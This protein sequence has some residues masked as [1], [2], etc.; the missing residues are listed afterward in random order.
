MATDQPVA[1]REVCEAEA[2]RIAA[3]PEPLRR[4]HLAALFSRSLYSDVCSEAELFLRA[5]GDPRGGE[6][7][8]AWLAESL[9]IGALAGV[10]AVHTVLGSGWAAQMPG[11]SALER[12][13]RVTSAAL[14]KFAQAAAARP[15]WLTGD[16]SALLG[17]EYGPTSVPGLEKARVEPLPAVRWLLD[18]PNAG[19]FVAMSLRQF[20]QGVPYNL[21]QDAPKLAVARLEAGFHLPGH[22]RLMQIARAL[23]PN[24]LGYRE[25][26]IRKAIDAR[27][28]KWEHDNPGK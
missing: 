17:F 14:C 28:R 22:G 6:Y 20:L 8:R 1:S 5:Y 9:P 19:D 21:K 11:A 27:V 25:D 2:S 24:F 26:S 23:Q 12:E 10:L 13:R 7:W 16:L 15:T 4:Q 3:L 18:N